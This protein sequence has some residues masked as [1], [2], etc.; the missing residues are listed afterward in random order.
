MLSLRKT[1]Q[2]G[3]LHRQLYTLSWDYENWAFHFCCNYGNKQ[4]ITYR[5]CLSQYILS[6]TNSVPCRPISVFE[7]SFKHISG[8]ITIKSLSNYGGISLDFD[9]SLFW[10]TLKTQHSLRY[11]YLLEG[12]YFQLLILK[13]TITIILA[14]IQWQNQN[15]LADGC[16]DVDKI[17]E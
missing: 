8:I 17:Q 16:C 5:T 10:R 2:N 9:W 12:E 6:K 4:H 1:N 13:L 7:K 11:A 14:C 15:M 3:L